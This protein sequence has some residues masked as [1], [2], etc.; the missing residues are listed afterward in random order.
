MASESPALSL[1]ISFSGD[2]GVE[3]MTLNLLEGLIERGFSIDLLLIKAR[4]PYVAQIPGGVNVIK[5]KANSALSCVPELVAY[6]DTVRPKLMMVAKHR[7]LVALIKAQEKATTTTKI[8][9]QIHT[10]TS[11]ALAHKPWARWFRFMSMRRF[12]SRADLILCVSKGVADDIAGITG[13]APERLPVIY[14]PVVTP[15]LMESSTEPVSHPWLQEGGSSAPVILGVGRFSEQ[16]GF[17]TLIR[18]FAELRQRIDVRLILLGRGE[19]LDSYVRLVAELGVEASISMPGFV[20]N[21]FAYMSKSKVFV[22]SSNWEGFGLVLAEA[23]SV[24]VPVVST[25]CPSGP[26]EILEGGRYGSLVP[27]GDFEQMAEAIFD[28]LV[29][30]DKRVNY[31]QAVERFTIDFCCD[32]YE[33]MLL[34]MQ[35]AVESL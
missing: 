23:L 22:L 34:A 30:V 32:Q 7:A 19:L 27:V 11:A 28:T 20:D 16:K 31:S 24:G 26:Q 25:D 14:N 33:K 2:G 13:M 4:G 18:A 15:A 21:P 8:V 35:P 3:R 10:N 29:S 12:Y 5:L 6:I 9:G 17:D 1:L